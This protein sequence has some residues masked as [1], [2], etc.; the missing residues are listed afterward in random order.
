MCEFLALVALQNSEL[1]RDPHRAPSEKGLQHRGWPYRVCGV[2]ADPMHAS[3]FSHQDSFTKCRFGSLRWLKALAR[4]KPVCDGLV[5][6]G[7]TGTAAI[8][9]EQGSSVSF[10]G[11]KCWWSGFPV[12]E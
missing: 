6:T 7:F 4:T 3:A 8:C 10:A 12:S 5:V 11:S 9:L 2:I 1:Y